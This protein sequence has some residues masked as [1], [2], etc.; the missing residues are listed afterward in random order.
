MEVPYQSGMNF[1]REYPGQWVGPTELEQK[2]EKLAADYHK[3]TEEY[4]RSV[5]TGPS[6]RGCIM[7]A[8]AEQHAL[9]NRN[10]RHL[11]EVAE[12]EAAALGGTQEQWRHALWGSRRR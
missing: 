8:N 2:L 1:M 3:R 7:P 11:R 5:C 6:V 4:D 10:A 9:I 12:A